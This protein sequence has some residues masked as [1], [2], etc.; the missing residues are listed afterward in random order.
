MLDIYIYIVLLVIAFKS[1][2]HVAK[3]IDDAKDKIDN[4]EEVA[5]S[6]HQQSTDNKVGTS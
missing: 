2:V 1:A 3:I 6:S 4:D 5:E